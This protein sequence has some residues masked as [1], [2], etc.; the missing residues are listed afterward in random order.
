[1]SDVIV[2][3]AGLAGLSAAKR[4]AEAGKS[5]TVLE[6]R[7]RVGGRTWTVTMG[8]GTFD[9]GGQWIG[10]G[11]PRISALVE[12]LGLE[13]SPT[14]SDGRKVLDLRGRLSSYT[15]LIPRINPW[16]LIATQIAMWRIDRMCKQVPIEAP[17][18][19]KKARE[20]DS[21]TVEAY[22][23]RTVRNKDAI[24]L[25]AS[26]ARVIFGSELGELSLLHFLHYLHS[27]GGLAKLIDTHGGNQ[28][29]RIVGGAQQICERMAEACGGV[30]YG[31]AVRRIEQSDGGVVVHGDEQSWNARQVVVAVPVGL[32]DRIRYTPPLPTLRDQLT[33]RVGMGATI[34]CVALYE[35]PFW[36]DA[37][38]SGEGVSTNGTVCVCFDNVSPEGQA[39]LL[40]FVVGA[41]GRGWAER[42]AEERKQ[43]VL[44][45]F[46][47]WFGDEALSPT[48]YREADWASE[49][50]SGGA[51]IAT[52]PPGAMSVMG[53]ALR[54]PVG[55][56]FWAGTETARESSGFMEGAVE[57][58][59]RAADEVIEALN[60]N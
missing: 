38:W 33:Q 48:D 6:A 30:T 13:T 19:A 27:G 32:A 16:S 58:G 31:A 41:P 28:D 10:P 14:F 4:I 49:E 5:V 50:F 52:F 37:G 9:V 42:S 57:S 2:V 56:I 17:W 25:V 35:R 34:K 7:D 29:A 26:A 43:E 15:G 59:Y 20:W 18:T 60:R 51:P 55:R 54:A 24:A 39:S 53:P 22:A 36:R 11:Q 45:T 44:D 21:T 40:A 12:E 3:G 46:A 8:E 1:M 23:R 47:R